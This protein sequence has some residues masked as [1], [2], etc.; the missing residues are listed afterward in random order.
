MLTHQTHPQGCPT[1]A[2]ACALPMQSF[3]CYS[4]S[5]L[6]QLLIWLRRQL[7]RTRLSLILSAVR[8]GGVGVASVREAV[9]S[10][11]EAHPEG[12]RRP[13]S[14]N[15][16]WGVC[17][18]RSDRGRRDAR[19]VSGSEDRRLSRRGGQQSCAI[20]RRVCSTVSATDPSSQPCSSTCLQP[21]ALCANSRIRGTSAGWQLRCSGDSTAAEGGCARMATVPA[22]EHEMLAELMSQLDNW[23]IDRYWSP[24]PPLLNIFMCA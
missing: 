17:R 20:C 6:A 13:G 12:C 15:S 24:S 5:L 21:T 4:R 16:S 10:G 7:T 9:K 14:S 3:K 11:P 2:T 19:H 22:D 8:A 18:R 1:T 23:S